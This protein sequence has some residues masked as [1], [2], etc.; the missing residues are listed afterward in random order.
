LFVFEVLDEDGSQIPF[1][2]TP[3]PL[4]TMLMFLTQA[5][6]PEIAAAAA[7]AALGRPFITSYTYNTLS[8]YTLSHF[9]LLTETFV[10]AEKETK[11]NNSEK[12]K[13]E[14]ESISTTI[15]NSEPLQQDKSKPSETSSSSDKTKKGIKLRKR[16][17]KIKEKSTKFIREM[18][19]DGLI[20]VKFNSG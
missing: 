13:L 11:Q 4:L 15:S 16:H 3:N 12:T 1:I 18:V 9:D 20:C 7:Q 5:V 6:Q 14:N 8:H 2:S 10:K 17:S 19:V